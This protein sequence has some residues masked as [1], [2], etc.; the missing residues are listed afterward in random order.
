MCV[1]DTR[2]YWEDRWIWVKLHGSYIVIIVCPVWPTKAVILSSIKTWLLIFV[3]VVVVVVFAFHTQ[4]HQQEYLSFLSGLQPEAYTLIESI[5]QQYAE[6][7]I[8][9]QKVT[10]QCLKNSMIKPECPPSKFRFLRGD[11]KEEEVMSLLRKV[12]EREISIQEME[13]EAKRVKQFKE[14]QR[15]FISE[16]GAKDWDESVER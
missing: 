12:S 3:V 8:K 4:I 7:S 9:G 10:K 1:I 11:L 14:V 2:W 16:I 15:C 13:K 5:Y 6:C